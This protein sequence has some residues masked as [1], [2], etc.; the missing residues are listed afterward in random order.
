MCES[1][2]YKVKQ[3]TRIRIMNIEL[4]GLKTGEYRELKGEEL[5]SLYRLCNMET[6]KKG[7]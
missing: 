3:L 2:G 7:V 1:L 5:S 4:K 6:G